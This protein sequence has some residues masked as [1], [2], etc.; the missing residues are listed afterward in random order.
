MHMVLLTCRGEVEGMGLWGS[1]WWRSE[2]VDR[3]GGGCGF[4]V[5]GICGGVLVMAQ[6][7]V[8][9]HDCSVAGSVMVGGWIEVWWWVSVAE[10]GVWWWV[11]VMAQI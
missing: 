1:A 10:I 6:I 3:R 9:V 2:F 4:V 5:T 7:K 11:L 8:W